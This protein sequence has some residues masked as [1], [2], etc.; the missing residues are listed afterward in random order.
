MSLSAAGLRLL[1]GADATY[2]FLAIWG[3]QSLRFPKRPAGTF[4]D[5]LLRVVG[6]VAAEALRREY[7]G[8]TCYVPTDAGAERAQRN[9]E[10]VVRL[11]SGESPAQVARTSQYLARVSPRQVLRIKQAAGL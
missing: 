8:Q 9:V 3:G 7:A 5:K 4:Y 11:A 10:I 1:I 2:R 6:P